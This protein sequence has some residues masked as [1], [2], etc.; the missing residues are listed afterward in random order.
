MKA[1]DFVAGIRDLI[2]DSLTEVHTALPARIIS[3]DHGS[4]T[5][6]VA[7]LIKN[8]VGTEKVNDY[9]ELLDVPITILGGGVSRMTFPPKI[10]D[11]GTVIF[12]ERDPSSFLQSTGEDSSD[13][14]MT[15][16]LGLYPLTFIPKISTASDTADPI[17][18]ENAEIQN[19]K[20]KV[21]L[22]P[23]GTVILSNPSGSAELK[24]NGDW[25]FKDGSGGTFAMTG[26]NLVYTGG[27][28]NLNG[29]IISPQG[30]LTDGNGTKFDNHKHTDVQPG[31]GQSGGPING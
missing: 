23:D 24:A 20:S 4:K 31:E 14:Y 29:L 8:R 16:P 30:L 15:Q 25:E 9:P 2:T 13:T 17:H 22:H 26:G 7:P 18:A 5:V 28:I 1:L 10:G 6:S 11:I 12:S 21:E 3:I 27:N 19:D